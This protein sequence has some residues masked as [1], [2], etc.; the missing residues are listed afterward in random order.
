MLLEHFRSFYTKNYP[1]DMEQCINSFAVFG[2]FGSAL[3]LD[4]SLEE[5]I[6]THILQKYDKHYNYISAMIQ[7]DDDTRD[8]LRAIAVGDRRIDSAFKR[9]HLSKSKGNNTLEFLYQNA[10]IEIEH[11]R[12]KAPKK[13]YR[14]Q[15]LK[16]EVARHK[17]SHKLRFTLPFLRF[18][19]YF[20]EP[21]HKDIKAGN[22]QTTLEFYKQHSKAFSGYI[23]EELSNLL[24]LQTHK[25]K[26]INSGSY[27][28][29]NVE[30]DILALSETMQII[31]GECKWT[32]HKV[33]KK[34]LHKLKDKC[35]KLNLSPDLIVLFC[36]RGFSNELSSCADEKL[37]L[38]KAEDFK[39]LLN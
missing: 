30:I 4:T 15:Q 3:D 11:S 19:F 6:T 35:K 16:R 32:N 14:K 21:H 18:W 23:F 27:W 36:K 12:E 25:S 28:D 2:G 24:L 38:Y 37:K 17:I 5:L 22:F 10:I 9:A 29:R 39:Q 1:N 8:L 13:L 20:I 33:N 31:V 26:I 34:E 7:N